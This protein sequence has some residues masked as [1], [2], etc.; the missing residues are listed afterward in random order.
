MGKVNLYFYLLAIVIC[1]IG[2]Y[3]L[4][5]SFSGLTGFSIIETKGDESSINAFYLAVGGLVIVIAGI[6]F[7]I[8]NSLNGAQIFV[9]H[10]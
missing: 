4:V 7:M 3:F 1:L 8:L 9:G 5:N 2:A 6:S 10:L